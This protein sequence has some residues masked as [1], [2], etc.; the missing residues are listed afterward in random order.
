[1]LLL[2]LPFLKGRL[3]FRAGIE[4]PEG[5]KQNPGHCIY[6]KVRDSYLFIVCPLWVCRGHPYRLLCSV[7]Q[8]CG[9]AGPLLIGG[10]RWPLRGKFH[11]LP[12]APTCFCSYV[13]TSS[14]ASA[15]WTHAGTLLPSGGGWSCSVAAVCTLPLAY[16]LTCLSICS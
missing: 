3:S 1:M 12:S 10:Q 6:F 5:R 14:H 9:P 16:D 4:R 2:T 7:F 13:S 15:S 8:R 11:I